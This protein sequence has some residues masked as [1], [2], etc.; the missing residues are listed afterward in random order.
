MSPDFF[1][2]RIG[3]AALAISA[4]TTAHAVPATYFGQ[5]PTANMTVPVGSQAVAAQNAFTSTLN[6]SVASEGFE[7]GFVR[8]Q[9]PSLTLFGGAATLTG[10]GKIQTDRC[11][12]TVN[13]TECPGRFNTTGNTASPTGQTPTDGHW[14]QSSSSFTITFDNVVSAFGFFLT[15]FGDYGSSL[16]LDLING[17]GTTTIGV[18]GFS[19]SQTGSLEFFGFTTD[20][21]GYNSITFNILQNQDPTLNPTGG[22]DIVGFDDLLIGS[23][24]AQPGGT[25]P[26]PA[27][28]ALAGMGLLGLAASRRKHHR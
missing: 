14:F 12:I 2:K 24:P 6:P 28:L 10:S 15:D 1:L 19:P 8:N 3:L 9:A 22:T 18:P 13:G 11:S 23:L 21:P 16:S 20:G 26:E 5:D 7:S 4:A 17:N 27:T 25:V